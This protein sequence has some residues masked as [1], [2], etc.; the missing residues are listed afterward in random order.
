MAMNA[1][2]KPLLHLPLFQGLKPLQLTEIVRRAGRIIYRPGDII[3]EDDQAGDAAIIIVSG[4]AVRVTGLDAGEAAEPI[5][6]GSMIGELAMLVET[7]HSATILARGTVKAL[8]ITR[9][10][11]HELMAEDPRLADHLTQK[12]TARLQRLAEELRAVDKAL[13][14]MTGYDA[15]LTTST[16]PAY[17]AA[18][19]H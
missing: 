12:I 2:V 19:L 9:A 14:D 16:M 7:V 8:R 15:V 11:M 13:A 6:E 17:T 3:I 5:A 18:Q 4:E 10:D 1:L